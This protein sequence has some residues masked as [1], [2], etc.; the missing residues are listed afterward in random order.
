MTEHTHHHI[1]TAVLK[2]VSSDNL[3]FTKEDNLVFFGEPCSGDI[4]MDVS[5]RTVI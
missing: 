5:I 1:L 2:I 3:L 4:L